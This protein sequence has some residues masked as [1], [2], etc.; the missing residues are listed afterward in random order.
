MDI[1]NH[2]FTLTVYFGEKRMLFVPIVDHKYGYSIESDWFVNTYDINAKDVG[3]CIIRAFY[4]M[5]SAPVSELTPAERDKN[6]AWRKCSK[7]KTW[8][9]FCKNNLMVQIEKYSDGHFEIQSLK[10]SEK[11]KGQYEGF[12]TE[13]T[14]PYSTT[15]D[16]LGKYTIDAFTELEEYYSKTSGSKRQAENINLLS[17]SLVEFD[18]P[19]DDHFI[20]SDDFGVGEIYKG[21]SYLPKEDADSV[22]EMFL[23]I[24]AELDCDL[25]PDNIRRRWEEYNGTAISFCCK[26]VNYGIFTVFA[27][28]KNKNIHKVSYFLKI[29]DSE[30]LECSLEVHN[31]NMRKKTDEK[32]RDLFYTFAGSCKFLTQDD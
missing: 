24:A 8:N 31:P 12:L 18:I 17:G 23:G 4:Y 10:R 20:D 25:T 13:K 32:L 21:Y 7:Y 16:D 11:H 19:A 30:I 6:A 29:D 27:E 2:R 14:L 28:L 5:N 26:V 9:S 22:A 1:N 3:D 15:Y